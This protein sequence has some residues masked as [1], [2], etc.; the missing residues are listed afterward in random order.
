MKT[1]T[2]SGLKD[3]RMEK[4]INKISGLTYEGRN[5]A[6]LMATAH[7]CKYQSNE[8]V[9]FLQAKS[10]GLSIRTGSH[11]VRIFK[12]FAQFDQKVKDKEGKEKIQTYSR[13]VGFATVFNLDQTWSEIKNDHRRTDNIN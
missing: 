7:K 8:W 1:A 6:E 4:Q 12:G 3:N 10:L 5:Q 11:G 13:P 9:T 2:M